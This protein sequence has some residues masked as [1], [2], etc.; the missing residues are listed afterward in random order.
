VLI[1]NITAH[2]DVLHDG[3]PL[4]AYAIGTIDDED[5][6]L[7]HYQT[8]LADGL[9]VVVPPEFVTEPAPKAKPEEPETPEEPEPVQKAPSRRTKR[10]PKGATKE[11]N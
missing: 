1:K 2:L 4:P 8:R 9:I 6:Q 3:R 11:K 7:P 5:S 10:A